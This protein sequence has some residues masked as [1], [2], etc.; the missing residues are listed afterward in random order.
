LR[1]GDPDLSSETIVRALRISRRLLQ[2][3]FVERDKALMVHVWTEQ[4]DRTD[5]TAK[6]LADPRAAHHSIREIA[7]ACGF[8]DGTHFRRV[9]AAPT[10]MTPTQWGRQAQ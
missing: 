1:C 2:R 9:F 3:I 6:L 4:V 10:G 7:F 8:S 5:R